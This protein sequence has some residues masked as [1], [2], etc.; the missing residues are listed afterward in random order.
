[1]SD[2]VG[3]KRLDSWKEIAA[4]LRC[5]ERTAMRWQEDGLP[6][7]HVGGR[8]RGRVFAY[9]QEIDAWLAGAK[10]AGPS[11]ATHHESVAAPAL[12]WL[13]RIPRIVQAGILAALAIGLYASAALIWKATSSAP[14]ASVTL[15]DNRFL[16][17]SKSGK[18]L[19]T[20]SLPTELAESPPT[21]PPAI[22]YIGDL[23]ASGGRQ[24]LVSVPMPGGLR[25]EMPANERELYFFTETGRL[26]WHFQ[27]KEILTFASGDYG[28]PWP[29]RV[30]LVYH[31]AGHTRIAIV[32]HHNTWWPSV[33]WLFDG[34][35]R[36]LGRFV[37]SGNIFALSSVDTPAGPLL[38]AGGVRNHEDE[39]SGMLAVLDGNHVTGS[40]P[41]QP[42]SGFECKSCPPERPLHYF[43]F[44]RSELNRL[45]PNGY[46][47]VVLIS[48]SE[49]GVTARSAEASDVPAARGK[50]VADG[51]FE[52]SPDFRLQRASYSD[53]YRELHKKWEREGKIN[54]PWEKCPDRFGPR[55]I[56]SWDPQHG[57]IE[58]HPNAG[59]R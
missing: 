52:F 17:V 16:G 21:R 8:G 50:I 4:Y 27:P 10:P 29:I 42:G 24:T 45:D 56:R 41:E 47:P 13:A 43:V 31:A 30:W 40:S 6:V 54:H 57:W 15:R 22:A 59:R 3:D 19:W 58:I 14:L 11:S 33:L 38:L 39:V 9:N 32:V 1:M 5:D 12:G 53:G 35:A 7:H 28:P 48:P 49:G 26:L 20:Y 25:S 44:P 51:I 23:Q 36:E 55:L 2:P 37:N 34:Q 46:N 18:T